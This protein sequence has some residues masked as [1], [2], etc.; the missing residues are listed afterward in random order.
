MGGTFRDC[1]RI[2]VR[3]FLLAALLTVAWLAWAAGSANAASN[4]PNPLGAIEQATVSLFQQTGSTLAPAIKDVPAP[5]AA[6]PFPVSG[7]A[8]TVVNVVDPVVGQ[9]AEAVGTVVNRAAPP[10]GNAVTGTVG[11]TVGTVSGTVD[12]V[13]TAV[14]S[15]APIVPGVQVPSLP[16]PTLPLPP[17]PIPAV[18]VPGIPVPTVPGPQVPLPQLPVQF[19][20][21]T[22]PGRSPVTAVPPSDSVAV[23]D[24]A[25]G[26]DLRASDR[27]VSQTATNTAAPLARRAVSSAEFLA[28]TQALR[29]MATAVGYVA[30]A[31]P[32][33]ATAPEPEQWFRFGALQSQSGSAAAGTGS[34]GAEASADVAAFW[35]TRHD[36]R[37][38]LMPDAALNPAAGPSFDPGSSPD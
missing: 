18:P 36:A 27:P 38:G 4:D 20:D 34:A 9:A 37:S 11:G 10:L 12:P 16:L 15:L 17:L 22:L 32:A 19:P 26:L 24:A 5:P 14:D 6:V 13:V 7:A 30:S 8:A 28:N 1:C 25:A 33:P 35:N 21:E 29:T 31:A 2:A 23:T 3:P